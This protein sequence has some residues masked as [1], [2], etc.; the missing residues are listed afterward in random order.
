MVTPVQ[1]AATYYR[2]S[3]SPLL[4]SALSRPRPSPNQAPPFRSRGRGGGHD[5]LQVAQER[6]AVPVHEDVAHLD[7][8]VRAAEGVQLGDRYCAIRSTKY[9]YIYMVKQKMVEI[10]ISYNKPSL[11]SCLPSLISASAFY[12]EIMSVKTAFFSMKPMRVTLSRFGSCTV[13]HST[14]GSR[15]V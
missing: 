14:L 12:L 9:I 6:C 11:T 1:V 5:K 13:P 10:S 8:G 4:Q 2:R 15:A 3:T 7:I